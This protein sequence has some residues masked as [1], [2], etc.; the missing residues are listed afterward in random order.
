[1]AHWRGC[2]V[3]KCWAVLLVFVVLAQGV[4]ASAAH[5][6]EG[7]FMAEAFRPGLEASLRQDWGFIALTETG[8]F[9]ADEAQARMHRI[10]LTENPIARQIDRRGKVPQ[11]AG[12]PIPQLFQYE[13]K[14]V[15]CYYNGAAK[16]VHKSGCSATCV[17][18]AVSY[19]T[20]ND[21]QSPEV[22]FRWACERGL[23]S[24]KGLWYTQISELAARWGVTGEWIERDAD[25]VRSELLAGHP[26]IAHMGPGTF[27]GGAH[28]ILLRGVD[29]DGKILVND[30]GSVDRT[31]IAYDLD[32]IVRQTRE[33]YPFMVLTAGQPKPV[34]E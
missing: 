8:G 14:T 28:Y 21:E 15:I 18:M 9:D 27:T 17:S 7:Y 1:M 29:A 25:R 16:S 12:M 13:Y 22:L 20:G 33:D 34:A 26:V 4:T 23:Y 11:D 2:G 30:P 31:K 10:S 5:Y 32:L 6:R 19:L 24:G 3:R